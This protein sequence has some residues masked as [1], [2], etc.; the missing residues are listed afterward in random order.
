MRL[1]SIPESELVGTYV[2]MPYQPMNV[3]KITEVLEPRT[4]SFNVKVAWMKE[5]KSGKITTTEWTNNLSNYEDLIA[6]HK[7]KV[8]THQDNLKKAKELLS[9]E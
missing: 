7:R 1:Y 3:G 8:K 9:T 4:G 6:D 2:Y 5:R